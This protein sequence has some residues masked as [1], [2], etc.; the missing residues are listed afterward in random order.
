MSVV[1]PFGVMHKRRLVP[2]LVFVDLHCGQMAGTIERHTKQFVRALKNCRLLLEHARLRRW[3]LAFVTPLHSQGR[4]K[5]ETPWWV[6][7]FE[8]SRND[9]VFDRSDASCYSSR[10]FADAISEV[11]GVFVLAGF[12]AEEACL[13]TMIDATR[14]GHR[15]GFVTDASATRPLPGHSAEES[16]RAVIA[17]ASRYATLTSTQR[18]IEIAGTTNSDLEPDHDTRQCR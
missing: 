11:G 9:M 10:E 14:N 17:L 1:I 8:P 6:P 4:R 12:S 2:P 18:W 16:H 7:G 5:R 15:A 3:Q 13:S